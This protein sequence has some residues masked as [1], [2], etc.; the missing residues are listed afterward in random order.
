MC[1]RDR[2]WSPYHNV[3]EGQE[4]PAVLIT[5]GKNDDRVNPVHSYK[6]AAQLQNAE[7]ADHPVYLRVD[8]HLGHGAG[9]TP[10]E[11]A[12]RYADQ[13]AFLLSELTDGD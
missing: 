13:W 7:T 9:A 4:Y 6:F 1:I 12:D 3:K 5:T 8:E 2:S 11:K 10:E